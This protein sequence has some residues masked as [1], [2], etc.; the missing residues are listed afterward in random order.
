MPQGQLSFYLLNLE[1]ITIFS[2]DFYHKV[3][4]P[5]VVLKEQI[6][7]SPNPLVSHNTELS[8]QA[9][10]H[11]NGLTYQRNSNAPTILWNLQSTQQRFCVLF[12][13]TVCLQWLDNS[14]QSTPLNWSG[15]F[16]FQSQKARN[17][18]SLSLL[19]TQTNPFCGLCIPSYKIKLK[20]GDS[21]QS[22]PEMPSICHEVQISIS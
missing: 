11:I 16:P 21:T 7:I 17:L 6:M 14:R 4:H 1:T 22:H 2:M 10:L 20:Y 15:L 13:I 5:H 18:S 19:P 3:H 9:Q 12:F 8:K